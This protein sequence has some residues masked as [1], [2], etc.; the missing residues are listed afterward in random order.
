MSEVI[1][2]SLKVI[3]SA[4]IAFL[5][6]LVI[7]KLLGKKQIAQLD[8]ISYVT[9]IS[10]GSI[11]A[12][13]STNAA[14]EPLYLYIISMTVF[15]LFD[16]LIGLLSRKGLWIEK[17]L[18]GSP[19]IIIENGKINYKALKKSKL[20][21]NEITAFAREKG[22]FSLDDIAFG[23]FESNGKFSI[24][25]KEE[26]SPVVAQDLKIKKDK[27]SLYYSVIVD[28]KI[29]KTALKKLGKDK[30]WMYK[31]LDLNKQKLNQILLAEYDQV[32][33]K[34]NIFYKNQ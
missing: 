15:F 20:T 26:K 32:S 21:I 2:G 11:A 4:S 13:M 10:I 9:G 22:Y 8:F 5:Y 17:L 14:K 7:S 27:A 18:V 31:K 29:S 6:L 23:I 28:G 30:D 16:F 3:M 25:P 33:K 34:F 12:E 19:L 1:T 24:L